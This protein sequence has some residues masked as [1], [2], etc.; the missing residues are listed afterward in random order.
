MRDEKGNNLHIK[1]IK[2]QAATACDDVSRDEIVSLIH[3]ASPKVARNA[4]WAM[5]HFS[6]DVIAT[7]R[8]RLNEFIDII[9][10]TD[11]ISLQRL[12]L[13]VVE[14]MEWESAYVRTDFLDFCFDRMVSPVVPPGV[15]SLCMKLAMRQCRFYPELLPEFRMLLESMETGYAVST[16][17]LRK[18]MLKQLNKTNL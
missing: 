3:D 11:N 1:D 4:A 13:N 8:P 5:T 15:Q 6:D 2:A 18:K 12:L 14:R 16:M 17:G 10:S 9:V 7:L